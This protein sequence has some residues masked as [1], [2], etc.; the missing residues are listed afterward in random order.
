MGVGR[1]LAASAELRRSSSEIVAR[2]LELQRSRWPTTF[3]SFTASQLARTEQDTGYHIEFLASSL[4]AG[5]QVLFDDY[6][7][8]VKTLF[9]TLGLPIEWLDGSLV[10]V[11]DAVS[12]ITSPEVATLAAQM[13]D[14]SLDMLAT[15]GTDIPSFMEP[16]HPL[17]GLGRRYLSAVL[18][19]DRRSATAMILEAAESGVAVA[20][21]YLHVFQRVQRELGRLWQAN[22]IT[23]AQ[24]HLATAVTQMVMSQLYSYVFSSEKG[25]HVLVASCVGGELHEIGMRMVADFF[26]MGRWD[27]YYLGA[28]TPAA[29]VVQTVVQTKAEVLALSATMSFNVQELADVVSVLRAEPRARNVR[30]LVGGYPF[31]LAPELW[32]TVGADGYAADASSA[33]KVADELVSR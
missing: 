22:T 5:E 20:D 16:I 33:L 23:V 4:W 28:N 3:E 32:S 29:S 1:N 31:N 9:V 8:W 26:E 11:R 19:G 6:V 12:D 21:I 30:V 14:G 2:A 10:D 7:A 18:G 27:T 15:R 24:E 13:I 17:G 25:S